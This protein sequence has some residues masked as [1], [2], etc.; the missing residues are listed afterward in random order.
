LNLERHHVYRSRRTVVRMNW[1]L[2]LDGSIEGYHIPAVH[3]KTAAPV[4]L[5]NQGVFEPRREH[6]KFFLAKRTFPR[7]R[8]QPA[9]QRR[10]RDHVLLAY[11]M[12]PCT[13]IECLSDV[14]GLHHILPLGP[15]TCVYYNTML[16]PEPADS[17]AQKR[18]LK[19]HYQLMCDV[20][21]EDFEVG[22]GVQHGIAS[23]AN[24]SFVF[25]RFEQGPIHMH[26][27]F[28]QALA[29]ELTSTG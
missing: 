23:G 10:L 6:L 29:G 22:E 3:K 12:F 1:K 21:S 11:V 16:I 27:L 15:D 20:F 9:L 25:G 24:R 2:A 7:L 19:S 28:K 5:N 17:D 13:I 26:R 18:Y 4:F 8:E 14:I